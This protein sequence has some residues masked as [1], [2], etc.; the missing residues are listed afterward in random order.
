MLTVKVKDR[1]RGLKKLK[2]NLKNT[3]K[4]FVKVG[5]FGDSASEAHAGT[6]K[7]NVEI[8]GFQEFG[9]S[10]IPTRSFIRATVD[11]EE[12]KIR[13]LQVQLGRKVLQG[14]TT[15]VQGLSV[16]GVFLQGAIQKR[17]QGGISPALSPKTIQ[18]KGSSKTLIDT[19]QL[20]Q[21][22]AWAVERGKLK[23]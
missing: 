21:S 2:R 3:G 19:G 14:K 11:A 4:H 7:S 13:K 9:T 12:A 8:A 15:E 16:M 5:I 10:R 23:A 1:D 20:V 18:R 6:Q 17:I 22:I